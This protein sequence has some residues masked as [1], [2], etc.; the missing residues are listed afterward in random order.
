MITAVIVD[1]EPNVV[2]NLALMLKEYCPEVSILGTANSQKDAHQIIENKMPDIV[3]LDIE[4]PNGNGFDLLKS[5]KKVDFQV[6]F[7]TAHS[8]YALDAIK[9]SALDYLLK[10]IDIDDLKGAVAKISAKVNSGDNPQLRELLQK[11]N[12]REL[13]HNKVAIPTMEGLE[14]ISLNDIIY[15]RADG[16]YTV[17]ELTGSLTIISSKRIGEYELLL[18]SSLFCRI[19]NSYLINL[20]HI[21]KYIKGKGGSVI[22]DNGKAIEVSIRKKEAFLEQFESRNA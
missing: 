11:L 1:D 22:M 14:F 17:I 7:V 16:H 2:M 5:F 6:I 3:F 21:R 15:C 9:V 13:S 8:H 10:P 18:P 20:K 4:M 12:S 19:H